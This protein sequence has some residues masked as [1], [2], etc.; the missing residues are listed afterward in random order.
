MIRLLIAGELTFRERILREAE[1]HPDCIRIVSIASNARDAMENLQRLQ[2]ECDAV[3]M[4]FSDEDNELVLRGL[5]EHSCK[6]AAFV[7]VQEPISGFKRWACHQA[8][9]AVI[10]K[11][12]SSIAG[13]FSTVERTNAFLTTNAGAVGFDK[14][15]DSEINNYQGDVK[16]VKIAGFFSFKGG[17][18]KSILTTSVAMSVA[19]HTDLSVCVVDLDCSRN[20]GDIIK[21]LGF[22]GKNR[23]QVHHT[24]V[25]WK[26]FPRD[27]HHS[28]PTV[29]EHLIKIRPRLYVLPA[30]RS[31]AET[32]KLSDEL[33]KETINTL[34][35]HMNLILFDLGNFLTDYVI[36]AMELSDDVFLVNTMDIPEIDSLSDFIQNVLPEIRIPQSRMHLVF[37]RIIQ[38]QKISVED[39]A[40]YVGL[41]CTA[42]IP[43]DMGVRLMVTNSRGQVPFVGSHNM[44][45]TR[46]VEKIILKL[47]PQTV[48][49]F[50]LDRSSPGF[51]GFLRKMGIG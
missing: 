9:C 8:V 1:M 2:D 3:L 14:T 20:Y 19:S 51:R 17:V 34:S 49:S 26:G 15:Q 35:L 4:G 33:L 18:G 13:Y 22:V 23:E 42:A 50:D 31:M 46:E 39:A 47:L 41:P 6:T 24:L 25:S 11:E 30:I 28:W 40:A 36:A 29:E 16:P 45:F 32:E 7:A 10:G 37:N 48:Y 43:E 44:P 27:Q 12:L 38:G 5:E 21:Y